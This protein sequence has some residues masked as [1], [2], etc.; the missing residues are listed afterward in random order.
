MT[1]PSID[2]NVQ[3]P[4]TYTGSFQA[5]SGGASFRIGGKT[6]QRPVCPFTGQ[7]MVQIVSS[8][9]SPVYGY[10]HGGGYN[11]AQLTES[12]GKAYNWRCVYNIVVQ[13]GDEVVA[14]PHIGSASEDPS[15]V[16][17]TVAITF[18]PMGEHK[19]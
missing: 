11:Y 18:Y 19:N 7:V 5:A 3:M 4:V 6:T 12:K 16:G 14:Y 8:S 17:T 2:L 1:T 9:K 10:A 15:N 13:K